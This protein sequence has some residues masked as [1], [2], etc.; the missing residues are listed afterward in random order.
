MQASL[1]ILKIYWNEYFKVVFLNI[2]NCAYKIPFCKC[3]H[4]CMYLFSK[5]KRV[6]LRCIV[7]YTTKYGLRDHYTQLYTWITALKICSSA[8]ITAIDLFITDYHLLTDQNQQPNDG[9]NC[10]NHS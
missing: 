5:A 3:I 6:S 7:V 8:A 4:I 9:L 10:H 2:Y 1:I